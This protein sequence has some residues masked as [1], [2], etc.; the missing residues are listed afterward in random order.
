MKRILTITVLCLFCLGSLWGQV[1]KG[2]DIDGATAN[3][4]SGHSLSMPNANTVAIGANQFDI[5][6]VNPG[7]VHIHDWDIVSSTWIQRGSDIVGEAG[8]DRAGHSVSMPDANTLAIGAIQND[9]NGTDAGHVRI[10]EWSGTAWQQKGADIDGEAA[11]DQSGYSVS[12][13]DANT[14]A[15]GAI[16]NDNFTGHIRIYE[17][18]GTAWQQKGADIDGEAANDQSGRAVSMPDANTV[19]IGALQRWQW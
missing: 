6:G 14:V 7:L 10:Y 4:R 19:A 11:G 12:M 9:G 3:D 17:W 2:G 15:I 13:P 5:G 8:G 1:Q 16:L 18:T